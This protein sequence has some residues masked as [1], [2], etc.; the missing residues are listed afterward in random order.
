MPD[1]NPNAPTWWDTAKL[2]AI[3]VAVLLFIGAAIGILYYAV[4]WLGLQ[5]ALAW[6]AFAALGIV[7]LKIDAQRVR[8]HRR[9]LADRKREQYLELLEIL[10]KCFYAQDPVQAARRQK[11]E[12]EK[13][14][15]RLALLGSD[16][17]LSAWEHFCQISLYGFERDEYEDE[18]QQDGEEEEDYE[19]EDPLFTA[20]VRL[21]TALRRDCGH[22]IQTTTGRWLAR[23]LEAGE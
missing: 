2:C 3:L 14:S 17:L 4:Q 12:L 9:V 21:L 8:E 13:W 10:R 22:R 18:E 5:A 16:E 15:L 19:P 7:L 20:Q 1:G 6:A 23:I 11:Q